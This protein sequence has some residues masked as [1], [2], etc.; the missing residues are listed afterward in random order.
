MLQNISLCKPDPESHRLFGKKYKK[1]IKTVP[2][3]GPYHMSLDVQVE[4]TSATRKLR[5]FG[6]Y[7]AQSR[8]FD[9]AD[10]ILE[11]TVE[12]SRL[13]TSHTVSFD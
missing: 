3:Q 5:D 13:P 9:E 11:P 12:I 4:S 2:L 1:P 6:V 8:N 10:P 7:R